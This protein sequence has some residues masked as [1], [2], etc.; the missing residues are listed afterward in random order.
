MIVAGS[1]PREL[2]SRSPGFN[3]WVKSQLRLQRRAGTRVEQIHIRPSRFN[4]ACESVTAS[5]LVLLVKD[6]GFGQAGS[7]SL[8]IRRGGGRLWS[9]RWT[10]DTVLDFGRRYEFEL[11]APQYRIDRCALFARR[12]RDGGLRWFAYTRAPEDVGDIPDRFLDG[13]L[14]D[15]LEWLVA[16]DAVPQARTLVQRWLGLDTAVDA[17]PAYLRPP[18]WR[19][20][21]FEKGQA[22]AKAGGGPPTADSV[23]LGWFASEFLAARNQPAAGDVPG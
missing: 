5:N 12:V 18:P 11:T 13:C 1:Q 2:G 20:I 4:R 21:A 10:F 3:T 16:I 7:A 22:I 14:P 19:T 8:R 15:I 9:C 17:R 6:R 23:W